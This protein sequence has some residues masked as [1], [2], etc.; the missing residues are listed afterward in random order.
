MK[1]STT[2]RQVIR[3]TDDAYTL[4][5]N[6]VK[7]IN[8]Y[9][10]GQFINFFVTIDGQE[11]IR[12]YSFSSAPETDLLPAV[13]IKRVPNGLLSHF[14]GTLRVGDVINVS[15]PYGRFILKD[16]TKKHL[17]IAGGSGI[18]P[19]FSLIKSLLSNSD[20]GL[21]TL[22]Y[23]SKRSDSIIF[24]D[25]L[26][27]LKKR[28]SNRLEV[29]YF[30]DESDE[31][32]ATDLL[33]RKINNSD[34]EHFMEGQA[35][36][37]VYAFICGPQ[38]L[39]TM[40]SESLKAQGLAHDRIVMETFSNKE[41]QLENMSSSSESS[42]IDI[43]LKERISIKVSREETILS[44]ALKMGLALPHSCKEAMCGTCQVKVLAGKVRMRENYALTDDQVDQGYALLC[45]SFATTDKVLLA[46]ENYTTNH[47]NGI[48]HSTGSRRNFTKQ[49]ISK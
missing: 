28:F 16:R 20:E 10:P 25:K 14:L 9:K 3:E 13:T 44:Q 24:R 47:P 5:F 32:T 42:T 6:A 34:L 33:N 30:V 7:G 23:S 37:N 40:A 43:L 4:V 19:I 49:L 35:K 21:I 38:G 45:T 1:V 2:I 27:D 22:L 29:K 18:T 15:E 12:Q 8:N 39:M 17:M 31:K 48:K 46:Y 36:E 41:G 11:V 26:D